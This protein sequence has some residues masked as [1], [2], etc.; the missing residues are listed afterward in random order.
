MLR[1]S[2]RAPFPRRSMS[3]RW[4]TPKETSWTYARSL[5]SLHFGIV[6][7]GAIGCLFGARLRLAGHD[8]TLIHRDS[9]VVRAI[10]KKGVRL[11]EIDGR[12]LIVRAVA[13]RGPTKLPGIE[14]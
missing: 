13:R 10:Q 4:T 6:G 9:S 1:R 2:D 8:V 5:D 7:A 12:F 11:Q 3:S 14:G